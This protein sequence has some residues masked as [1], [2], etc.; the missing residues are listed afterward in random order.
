MRFKE[1]L[2]HYSNSFI[3]GHFVAFHNFEGTL[4]LDLLLISNF[5]ISEFKLGKHFTKIGE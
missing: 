4:R 1:K 5:P 2:N 3:Y